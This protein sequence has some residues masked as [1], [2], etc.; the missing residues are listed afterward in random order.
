MALSY[1][2][3]SYLKKAQLKQQSLY[4]GNLLLEEHDPP[5]LYDSEETLE[6]A[7]ESRDK[8]RFLKKEIKLANYA[9]INHLLGVFVPQTTKSKEELF[10]SNVSNM[11]TVSKTISIPNED[12]SDDTS[13]SVARKFLNEVKSPLVTLQRVV[14]QK[15]TLEVHNWLYSPYKEV[16][17]DLQT[18]LDRTKEKLELR[19]IKKEKEYAV[20]W[21]NCH[22]KTT[23]KNLFDSIT[24][25]RAHAKLY[26]HIYEN[27][28]LRAWVFENTSESIKNT[29]G[30]SVTPHVD[31][32]KLSDVTPHSKKLHASTPSHSIPQ[33]REFNVVKH[34]NGNGSSNMVTA[35]STGVYNR[36]TKKIMEMMNVTFDELSTKAF[37]QNSLRSSKP[38]E[39]DLDILFEPLHN[40]YLGGRPSEA[41]RTIPVSPVSLILIIQ[42]MSTNSKG[43]VWVKESTESMVYVD[44]IIFGSTNPRY[45]TLF[46]DLM[47]SRFEMMMMGE[48]MFFLGL[49][50][51]QSP[52]GIFI[53]QSNYVNEIFKKY[54][55]NTCNIIGTL[56][57][58][59]DKLDLDQIETPVD[60]TKY[61]SM[62]GALM[63]LTSSRLNIVHATCD[64]GFELTGFSNADYAGCKD[65]FK[66][67]SGGAQFLGQKLVSWSSKKQDYTSLSTAKSE[68]VSLS[69]C[70]AQVLWMRTQLTNYGYHFD[71]IPIYYDTK[72][73]IAISCNP[74]QHSKTKHIAVRYHFIKEHVEK[75]TIELYF[76]KTDYQLADIFTKALLVDTFNYL[77][78][79][80]RMRSLCPQELDRLAKLHANSWQWEHPPLAVRTYTASGNSLLEVG[81]PCAFYSQHL[82]TC[83][84]LRIRRIL[85][86][87]GEAAIKG[88][89]LQGS[90]ELQRA[91]K[92][93]IK[94]AQ[95]GMCLLKHLL[96][97]YWFHGLGGYD[98]NDQAEDGSTNFALMAYSSTSSNSEVSTDSNY[99]SSCLEN[100][101]ILKEQNEQL[102]KD[103]RISKIN[104]ITYKT[105]LG[106][107]A[108]PPPYT[109]NFLPLK[110]YLSGLEEFVNE[111]IVNE[112]TVKKPAV[113][114]SKAKA[115]AD[116]PKDGN[117][118]IDLQDKGVINS[119][120]SRYMT[121]KMSYLTYYKEIDRG[122]VAFED[123]KVK[124]IRCDNGTEFKNRE[125]NQY[126]EMKEAVNTACYVQN[127][128]LVVKPHNKIPYELFHGRTPVL[129]LM[130]PSG[131]SVTILNTKDH[132][133]KFNGKADEGFFVRYSLNSKAFR[134]F[135][136]RTRIVGEN[137]H[138]SDD[139]KNVDEDP[140]QE[141]ECKD[142]EKEDNIN[143][144]NNVNVAGTNGV[145]A[146]RANT[147]NQL[148][149]DPE[150]P[151]LGDISTFNFSN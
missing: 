132:L 120:C 28:Q 57:D 96:L 16:P 15:M 72:S 135:N 142:Q 6:L 119:G 13:L 56:I 40:E 41:P 129:S 151:N 89:T 95:E 141:S 117:P 102:L 55:L 79:L 27:A 149:F 10:L 44:D 84:S 110:P 24:S 131:C 146:I 147:N 80:L 46:S 30:I 33:P 114:T 97:R 7:Q 43:T 12:L 90:V 74:V 108:V 140:R 92:T 61:H 42:A 58:I 3:P 8:M 115:N 47:K 101:K 125:M 2:N 11:V 29:L 34:R 52:S 83:R 105:G 20:L 31:K 32:P 148:P 91:T 63:Y 136:K 77:V 145:N 53:N 111:P 124:V 121:G 17:S 9:K 45:A 54:G 73:A 98:W 39:R 150:M 123:H 99:S 78:R 60:A 37:E 106:Y 62:I 69:A 75:G 14:K 133:G 18:E 70:C 25:N 49:Q 93:R 113:E 68:Y 126:C 144:T 48:M 82:I 71:K 122:Y 138:I 130:R 88:D 143:I 134:V 116:K 59:K 137:L 1:L 87:G 107:N 94:K 23:Y 5:A 127:R 103:L 76:V 86:D 109:G 128:V 26:D 50:V 51:N 22:L 112:P 85:K 64:S 65:T 67:T 66:S 38:S 21:N 139:G 104:A 19:I 36:R 4:N 118:E 35:S 100:V 81:M